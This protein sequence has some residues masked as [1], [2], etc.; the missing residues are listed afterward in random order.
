MGTGPTRPPTCLHAD[1]LSSQG[2]AEIIIF[3]TRPL[4]LYSA[5]SL[6]SELGNGVPPHEAP[7]LKP[8]PLCSLPLAITFSFLAPFADSLHIIQ[9]SQRLRWWGNKYEKATKLI[10]PT[11]FI[12]VRL[13]QDYRYKQKRPAAHAPG[14]GPALRTP[15]ES[16]A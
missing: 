7:S 12:F 6:F 8:I 15:H 1:S 5:P 13:E 10:M 4:S 3:L 9:V 14:V 2:Y 16:L 11:G